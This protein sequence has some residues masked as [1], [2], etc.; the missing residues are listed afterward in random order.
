MPIKKKKKV[1][2]MKG[3]HTTWTAEE[4]ESTDESPG[5]RVL[6]FVGSGFAV[7]IQPAEWEGK[8]WGKQLG[9]GR[10]LQRYESK[11]RFTGAK[12]R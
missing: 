2:F 10:V 12:P 11:R 6:G 3:G 1:F 4:P 9:R 8:K 7:I 5:A